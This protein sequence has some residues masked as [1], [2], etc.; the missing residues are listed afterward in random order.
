M[1]SDQFAPARRGVVE[2]TVAMLGFELGKEFGEG[3][4]V[5]AAFLPT[6]W[7]DGDYAVGG[8]D[9]DFRTLSQSDLFGKRFGDSDSEAVAPLLYG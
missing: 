5:T 4:A 7:P 8:V 6:A 2:F 1:G 3:G 9:F